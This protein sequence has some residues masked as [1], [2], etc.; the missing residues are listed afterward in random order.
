MRS[1]G[2]S[3][4][5]FQWLNTKSYGLPHGLGVGGTLEGFR[6]F[7]TD[8]FEQC[9]AAESCLTFETGKLISTGATASVEQIPGMPG[10]VRFEIDTLEVWACGGEEV[11]SK[12]MDYMKKDREIREENIQKA[13]KVDKAQ[14]FNNS[15]DREFLLSNTFAHKQQ[16][17]DDGDC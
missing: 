13:R 9:M 12:G 4:G 2:H 1:R 3:N 15:F 8:S 11:I 5:N 10:R 6:L 7:I 17:R 14:F 16:Q